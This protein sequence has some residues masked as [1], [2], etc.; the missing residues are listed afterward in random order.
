MNGFQILPTIPPRFTASKAGLAFAIFALR[1]EF[2][3]D[4][5]FQLIVMIRILPKAWN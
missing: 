5:T 1:L 3:S 2:H 4:Q